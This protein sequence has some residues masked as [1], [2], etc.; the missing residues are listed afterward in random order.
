MDAF[1]ANPGSLTPRCAPQKLNGVFV[2]IVFCVKKNYIKIEGKF[3]LLLLFA[4]TL[5]RCTEIGGAS[6]DGWLSLTAGGSFDDS[7]KSVRVVTF[8]FFVGIGIVSGVLLGILCC[9]VDTTFFR[10]QRRKKSTNDSSD[11]IG[12]VHVVLSLRMSG[13]NRLLSTVTTRRDE[14]NELVDEKESV[15]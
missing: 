1:C 6:F 5:V 13:V 11:V 10:T 8:F 9:V 2:Y 3:S 4:L 12:R 15:R 14:S 7:K